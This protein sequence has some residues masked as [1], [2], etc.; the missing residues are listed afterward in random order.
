MSY[1]YNLQ[2]WEVCSRFL[3]ENREYSKDFLLSITG[4]RVFNNRR[5]KGGVNIL[6]NVIR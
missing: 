5:K 3:Y 6:R 1:A 4:E 2:N